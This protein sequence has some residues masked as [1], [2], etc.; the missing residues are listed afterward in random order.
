MIF[1]QFS[2]IQTI[3]QQLN[4]FYFCST[5]QIIAKINYSRMKNCINHF[6][7]VQ[8]FTYQFTPVSCRRCDVINRGFSG[9]NSRW[10]KEMIPKLIDEGL[11]YRILVVD[12][13]M[14][15]I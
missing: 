9:Y 1:S 14:Y 15:I 12:N 5:F 4:V 11:C 2:M 7:A 8:N 3:S 6:S 13:I 10:L